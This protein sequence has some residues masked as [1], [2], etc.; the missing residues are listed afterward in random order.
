MD[1]KFF[2]IA[3]LLIIGGIVLSACAGMI[4][5]SGDPRTTPDANNMATQSAMQTEIAYLSTK[6]AQITPPGEAA[7]SATP[8]PPTPTATL[9]PPA[10]TAVPTPTPVLPTATPTTPPL[11]CNAAL[12]L[13]DITIPDGSILS[14]GAGFT[15]TWRLQN[16]GACAWTTGYALVFVDGSRLGAPGEVLLPGDVYPGETIDLPV[17]MVAPDQEGRYRGNWM[18]RD[19][20]GVLFGLGRKNSVFYV[21]IRVDGTASSGP[22]DFAAAYCQAEWSSGAGRLP[23]QGQNNDS[24]GYVRRI[25]TPTLETGYVDDEPALLTHPQMISDGFIRGKYPAIHV[26]ENYYFAAVIGCAH[27]A[28][29]CDVTFRLDYQIGSGRIRNLGAWSEV[30]DDAF[31]LVEVDLSELAGEDVK[32]I[33]TVI[34][35]GNSSQNR[36]QW[37]APHISDRD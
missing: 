35:N 6:V 29:A 5:I 12:F 22:L 11:P 17:D 25:E 14:P 4:P 19:S 23:C 37:L 13:G 32:F 30:Y 16:A 3:G 9:E 26:K 24:R 2:F 27:E 21:D 8:V 7:A 31:Q 1:R 34:A 28:A 18:L 15:K 20:A 33:L 10:P 36:A